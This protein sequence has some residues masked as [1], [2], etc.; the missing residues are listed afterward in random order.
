[1]DCQ[2]A[3]WEHTRS[4][5]ALGRPLCWLKVKDIAYLFRSCSASEDS[6]AW[7]VEAVEGIED[8]RC[9]ERQCDRSRFR[10]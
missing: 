1:M 9:E 5:V 8:R 3:H 6:P 2:P 10:S 7:L 4:A